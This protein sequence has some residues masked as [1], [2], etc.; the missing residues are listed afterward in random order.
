MDNVYSQHIYDLFNLK[1]NMFM[2]PLTINDASS[3]APICVICSGLFYTYANMGVK[4]NL[5]TSVVSLSYSRKLSNIT[6]DHNYSNSIRKQ[7][8]ANV[9]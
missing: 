6:S 2:A 9:Q 7:I 8:L 3:H 4:L 5:H 1:S